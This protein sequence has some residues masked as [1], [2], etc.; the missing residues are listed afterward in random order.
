MHITG[1]DSR[2]N[3]SDADELTQES[4]LRLFETGLLH[5]IDES[6]GTLLTLLF[7]VMQKTKH[8]LVRKK[9]HWRAVPY[10]QEAESE[11]SS[12]LD[13][14]IEA[15]ELDL[16]HGWCEELT[17]CELEGLILV[18]SGEIDREQIEPKHRIAA[19]RA[20]Q[21]LIEKGRQYREK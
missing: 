21:K 6:K 14:M 7:G 16:V 13:R 17:E 9:R 19:C 18:C 20:L 12:P 8:E 4:F 10:G 15:E 11:S 5:R 3:R 1:R 2:L